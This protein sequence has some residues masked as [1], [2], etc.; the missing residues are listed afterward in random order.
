MSKTARQAATGYRPS[1][2][3][4]AEC[5]YAKHDC[6][7]LEFDQMPPAGKRDADGVQRVAC[8]YYVRADEHPC[9][10]ALASG[11]HKMGCNA[12]T[13]QCPECGQRG[14]H[15]LGCSR[16]DP[17]RVELPATRDAGGMVAVASGNRSK[18]LEELSVQRNRRIER[19]RAEDALKPRQPDPM[20]GDPLDMPLP[21]DIKIGHGTHRKGTSLRGLVMRARLL[22]DMV[23]EQQPDGGQSIDDVRKQISDI[24]LKQLQELLD[25]GRTGRMD[26]HGEGEE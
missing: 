10:G 9:C 8:S 6:S 3:Q 4:C 15:K 2:R 20:P 5:H 23:Q 25:M 17:E 12:E 26:G 21:C 13:T 24:R 1:G 18:T 22:Y 16:R 14:W 19:Q 7:G 11:P